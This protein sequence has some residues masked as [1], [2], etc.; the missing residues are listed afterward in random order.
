MTTRESD[1][2]ENVLTVDGD[3]RHH[4]FTDNGVQVWSAG[5]VGGATACRVR[6]V[7]WGEHEQVDQCPKCGRFHSIHNPPVCFGCAVG[8]N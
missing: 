8:L 5:V 7:E 2:S 6:L 4:K 3:G 1:D